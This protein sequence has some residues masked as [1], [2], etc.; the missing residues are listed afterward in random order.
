MERR[1]YR[2][3]HGQLCMGQTEAPGARGVQGVDQLPAAETPSYS[4]GRGR[5]KLYL[6]A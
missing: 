4:A 1:D 5:L 6:A 2:C 3:R